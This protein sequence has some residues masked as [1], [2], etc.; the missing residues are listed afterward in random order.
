MADLAIGACAGS[1]G[2]IDNPLNGRK[3]IRIRR[4]L[5]DFEREPLIRPFG[6]EGA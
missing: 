4:V 3:T 5:S 2:A 1:L 6:P